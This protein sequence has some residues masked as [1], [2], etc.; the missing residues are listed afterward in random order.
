MRHTHSLAKAHNLSREVLMVGQSKEDGLY[1]IHVSI[2]D[3]VRKESCYYF[4]DGTAHISQAVE[5]AVDRATEVFLGIGSVVAQAIH[6]KVEAAIPQ[7]S[8]QTGAS[9][10]E[11]SKEGGE[12]VVPK[13]E[14]KSRSK[15]EEV[16]QATPA[17]KEEEMEVVESPFKASEPE[18]EVK[19]EKKTKKSSAEPYNREDKTSK[20]SF[21]SYVTKLHN[22]GKDWKARADLKDISTALHG[23]PFLEKDGSVTEEF[24]AKCRELFGLDD[25]PAL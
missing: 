22:G 10:G 3:H 18:P 23:I 11:A 9:H 7:V 8:E 19:E 25:E 15:K 4:I 12:E 2:A 14:R 17:S 1:K 5:A 20:A 24:Q 21:A 13:K 16:A 6:D